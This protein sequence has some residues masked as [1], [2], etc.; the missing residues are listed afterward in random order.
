MSRFRFDKDR[1]RE[2]SYKNVA[3]IHR[4]ENG[5]LCRK[6]IV[7]ILITGVVGEVT[8]FPN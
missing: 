2:I 1:K 7:G 8:D 6:L 5:C 3:K 4:R